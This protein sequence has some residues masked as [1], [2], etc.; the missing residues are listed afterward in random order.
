MN[1]QTTAPTTPFCPKKWWGKWK[2]T[3]PAL[4]I[5][6]CLLHIWLAEWHVQKGS[7]SDPGESGPVCLT[8]LRVSCQLESE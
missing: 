6:V 7:A 4:R 1:K 2:G 5:Q 8:L 3:V